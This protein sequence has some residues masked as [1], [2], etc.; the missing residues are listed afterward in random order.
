MPS[1][2]HKQLELLD[3]ILNRALDDDEQYKRLMIKNHKASKSVGESWM[4]HH[5]KALKDLI[6]KD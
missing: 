6:N 1:N 2:K 5:L 4:V 3:Q